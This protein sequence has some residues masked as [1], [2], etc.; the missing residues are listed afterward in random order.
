LASAGREFIPIEDEL[1]LSNC[2]LVGDI[3]DLFRV[4]KASVDRIGRDTVRR[5]R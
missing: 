5:P 3:L 1:A 4:I 2:T